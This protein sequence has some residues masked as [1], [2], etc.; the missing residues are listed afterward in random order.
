MLFA[1]PFLTQIAIK[2]LLLFFS[3]P[4]PPT[5]LFVPKKKKPLPKCIG[6]CINRNSASMHPR[7]HIKRPSKPILNKN[8]I[9][10]KGPQPT[11]LDF[12]NSNHLHDT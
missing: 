1:T 5:H 3:S 6:N 9:M 7:P 10:T 4:P 8:K 2:K 11:N 12:Q